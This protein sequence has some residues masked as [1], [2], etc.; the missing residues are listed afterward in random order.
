MI[1]WANI[2]LLSLSACACATLPKATGGSG[3]S[4]YTAHEFNDKDVDNQGQPLGFEQQ[5]GATV[6][7][8]AK[9]DNATCVSVSDGVLHIKAR[10]LDAPVDNGYGKTVEYAQ[11][12][13]RSAK[14]NSSQFWCCFTENMRIEVR[15]RRS[16][17]TGLNDAI[18][19]MP[20]GSG[21]WP[22]CGEI[23]LLENPKK[24]INNRAHFT[25]HTEHHYSGNGGSGGITAS[26]KVEDMSDWNIYWMEWYPDKIIGGVND[27]AYFTH[28]KGDTEDWPW[29]QEEGFYLI[30][31]RGLSTD[32][33][34]WM[35]A[36]DY[37][38]WPTPDAP[39]MD[40]DWI[41]VYTNKDFKGPKAPKIKYY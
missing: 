41:R 10:R 2:L 19:F 18:W 23:D 33:D 7:R 40:I 13:L 14:P 11:G 25:L 35:G 29:S 39:T 31:S 37:S 12:A 17:Y 27:T 28:H 9:V 5:T 26:T 8:G 4:F 15:A 38:T 1:K 21:K 24:K 20:N 22:A 16:A 36:V 32:A 6:N 34:R 30:L 3:W